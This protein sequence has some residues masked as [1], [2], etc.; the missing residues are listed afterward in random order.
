MTIKLVLVALP[1]VL[2]PCASAQTTLLTWDVN[3][4][5][6][7]SSNPLAGT[8]TSGSASGNLTLGAG[9]AASSAAS[10]FGGTGFDQ[11]SFN[12]AFTGQDYI[13]FSITATAGYALNLTS[14]DYL[15]G[16]ASGTTSFSAFLTS[17]RT[18][19]SSTD[20]LDTYTFTTSSPTLR[21]ITLSGITSLQN[22]TGTIEFRL[23]GVSSSTD[24]FRIRSNAGGDLTIKGTA[25]AVPEPATTGVLAGIVIFLGVIIARRRNA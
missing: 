10:T 15:A 20:A 21:S 23:Y 4:V 7:A 25:T 12:A 17:D 19:F 14:L 1:C 3:G 2:L 13:A 6:A 24:T 5:N 11:A 8:N 22:I 18:G 9:V 16:K